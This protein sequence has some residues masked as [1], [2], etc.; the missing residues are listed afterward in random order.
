[1][2]LLDTNM[3][4]WTPTAQQLAWTETTLLRRA[5]IHFLQGYLDLRTRWLAKKK[6]MSHL[7]KVKHMDKHWP[8]NK[9]KGIQYDISNQPQREIA[10]FFYQFTSPLAPP[11]HCA[12]SPWIQAPY[13]YRYSQ[14]PCGESA[15]IWVNLSYLFNVAFWSA[16]AMKFGGVSDTCFNPGSH[17]FTHHCGGLIVQYI[18]VL[19]IFLGVF[20]F[21]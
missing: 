6:V 16:L 10:W 7:E 15:T 8:L 1:M 12:S 4:F 14:T 18:Y 3:G 20:S 5:G 19:Y 17:K 13:P 11:P 21:K 9:I 2:N